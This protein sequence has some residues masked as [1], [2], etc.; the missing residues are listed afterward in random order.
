VLKSG[1]RGRRPATGRA[2]SR[3]LLAVALSATL[4]A[5][6]A[7]AS[8]Q[9]RQRTPYSGLG[10]WLDIYAG[11]AWSHPE[12]EVRAMARAG[13]RTLFLQTGNYEERSDLVRPPALGRFLDAAHEDGM[14]V[15]AWYLPSFAAA[16]QDERRALA[17]IRFR[18]RHG[19]RFDAF[20]LDIEASLVKP[21]S[22]RTRRLLRLSS[23]LRAA[24]GRRY[25]L[26]AVIPS[27]V[28]MRRHPSY[29]PAFPYRPLARI[30]DVFLPMAYFTDAGVHGGAATRAYLAADIAAI[31]SRTG[32]PHVPIHLIGGIAGSMGRR[33]TAGFMRAVADCAPLGY[34][35]YEFPITRSAAWTAL[36]ARPP[37]SGKRRCTARRAPGTVVFPSG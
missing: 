9:P 34:S 5:P 37:A 3:L 32:R 26:G 18:S 21:A 10:T 29:W 33:E 36:T 6:A 30:Y 28:G 11:P 1:N 8:G 27:P 23:R 17:A 14:R 4:V 12:Q 22:L 31:R 24:V 2:V 13:A 15:V 7:G 35:L 25:P 19:G 20:A 16:G